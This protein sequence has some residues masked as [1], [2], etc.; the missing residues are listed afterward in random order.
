[1]RKLLNFLLL[2]NRHSLIDMKFID[3]QIH[4]HSHLVSCLMAQ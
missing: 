4:T 3:N 1:M 2:Y